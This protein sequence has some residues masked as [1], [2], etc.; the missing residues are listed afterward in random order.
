MSKELS[1]CSHVFLRVGAA[2]RSLDPPYSGPHKV[3]N[4]VTDRIIK[5]DV[6]G[7]TKRVPLKNVKPAHMLRNLEIQAPQDIPPT[8][9]VTN[10]PVSGNVKPS[11]DVI[12]NFQPEDLP[13]HENPTNNSESQ[14]VPNVI[15]DVTISQPRTCSQRH[16]PNILRKS[17]AK[18]VTFKC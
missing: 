3:L 17:D 2:R 18:K 11:T 15:D 4:R 1:T 12:P 7:T 8:T 10:S 9:L 14:C 5:I 13:L 6:N 16:I